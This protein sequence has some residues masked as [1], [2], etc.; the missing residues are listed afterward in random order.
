VSARL[1]AIDGAS[2][3]GGGQILRTALSLSAVT[4]QGFEMTRIRA[5]RVRSGLRPQHLAAIRAVGMACGAKVNGAFDGSPDLRFEASLRDVRS[6]AADGND[7]QV[8]LLSDGL[9][10]DASRFVTVA[11]VDLRYPEYQGEGGNG[12]LFV[13][14]GSECLVTRATAVGGRHNYS[15]GLMQTTGNVLHDSSSTDARLPSDFHMHLSA[16]NLIDGLRLDGDFVEARR[17][18]C[19]GHGHSTTQSVIWNAEG[20][21]YP[22]DQIWDHYIV[23]S[24]Q[25]GDGYVIGTRGAAPSVRTPGD[26]GTA[27]TDWVEGEGDGEA[28][29]PVSLYEDQRARRYGVVETPG[30]DAG[31]VAP[32]AG[33]DPGRDAS[34]APPGRDAGAEPGLDAAADPGGGTS[35]YAADCG[36]RLVAARDPVPRGLLLVLVASVAA[37]RRRARRSGG[38]HPRFDASERSTSE[39]L[40]PRR[41]A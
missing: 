23:D 11:D 19:C 24:A 34:V 25:F 37:R 3:E 14:S 40:S 13:F 30:E 16:A 9:R 17:R 29:E 7:P 12:D 36:C 39:T 27:P 2:G 8:H 26:E 18:A 21:D 6:F 41:R 38:R 4:G 33:P 22:S 1:I 35:G 10:T 28:L 5:G 31:P 32:D 15:F 20:I